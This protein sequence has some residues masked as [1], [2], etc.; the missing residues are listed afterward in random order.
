MP[1]EWFG[2][3]IVHGEIVTNGFLELDRTAMRSAFDLT[4]AEQAKPALD[5]IEPG[6]GSGCEVQME[7]WMARKPCLYL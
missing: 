6:A 7:S 3:L 5:Q 2:I 1:H 4:L